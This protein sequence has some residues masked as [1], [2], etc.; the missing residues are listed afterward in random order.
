MKITLYIDGSNLNLSAKNHGLEIDLNLMLL[1]LKE[2][3]YINSCKYF[4]P[5]FKF[6][7]T[8]FE[9]LKQSGVEIIYKKI[10]REDKKV[11]ANCDVEISHHITL[12]VR[13]GKVDK[14]IL[15]TGDGDFYSLLEYIESNNVE[16]KIIAI[17]PKD[18]SRLYRN[19]NKFGLTYLS[20]VKEKIIKGKT[21][22]GGPVRVFFDS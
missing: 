17:Y 1:Y 15:L 19:S 11:K 6:L 13:D 18:T 7:E 2:K 5:N 22:T 12:D 4:T 10:Y 9:I 16:A 20:Q 8:E 3:Y 21:L 14:V